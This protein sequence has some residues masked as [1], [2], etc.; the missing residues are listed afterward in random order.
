MK[1]AFVFPGQGSQSVGMMDAWAGNAAVADVL[2]RASQALGQDLAALIAQGPADQLNLTTNTQ[3]AMLAAGVAC[4]AAWRDAGGPLPAVM[5][6]HSLGEYAALTAA[7]SLALEDAVRLVRIRA[8]AMQA[9]VPV[10]TGA[11]AAILG[12]DDD[13]VR[14]AC[15][16]GAQGEAVEA[17][18]F[19]APA[20]VVIAGHKAAVERA[21]EAAKAAGAK[22]AL[23][24]PVSAPFHS[25][26]LKP[27]AEVL[28]KA[29]ADAAVHSPAVPVINNVD[30]ALPSDPA[31]IRNALVRQAWH[32]VRWV[33][34]VQ[35]MKAQGVTHVIE[36]GPGKVLTGLTKRID[37]DLTGLAVTDPASLD[38]ALALVKGN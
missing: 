29:L 28:A 16:Q 1:L 30:V 18:N 35:A 36:F 3:P 25:S 12:L 24:L 2:A 20:Q 14:A 19:N 15:A 21:C 31:A 8:D 9:A 37:G 17:V 32:A 27:A 6:G 7:Q 38:A 10:G 13:A 4:F 23:L 5:A 34:T 26:L 11:M 33:E 22:R